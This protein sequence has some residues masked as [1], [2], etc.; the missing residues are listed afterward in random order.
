M[1]RTLLAVSAFMMLIL[2]HPQTIARPGA[3]SN[4]AVF[5]DDGA[6]CITDFISRAGRSIDFIA[7]RLDQGPIADVL[8]SAAA[9]GVRVRVMLDKNPEKGA[10]ANAAVMAKLSAAHA[11]TNSTNPRFDAT[12]AR[13]IIADSSRAIV[14]SFDPVQENL[15]GARGF[16]VTLKDPLDVADLSWMYDADWSRVKVG[17][18]QSSLTWE[19]DGARKKLLDVI[20]GAKES[21]DIYTDDVKDHEIQKS[22]ADAV[23]RGV[24]VR[25]LAGDSPGCPMPGLVQLRMDGGSFKCMKGLPLAA[26]AMMA[27]DGFGGRTALIGISKLESPRQGETRGL[28]VVI[29]DAGR[30]GRLRDTFLKDWKAAK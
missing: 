5:P 26:K 2:F 14:L 28:G 27:D 13:A 10:D 17:P 7:N 9:R 18:K 30:L 6:T 12:I 25:V 29:S 4:I 11:F 16:A 21:I 22:F 19:P 23:R 1:K 20:A 3:T 8:A 24:I 15:A